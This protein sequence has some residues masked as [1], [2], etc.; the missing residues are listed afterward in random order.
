MNVES[1][2]EHYA[3]YYLD[4]VN[5][6]E[7]FLYEPP[8]KLMEQLGYGN[9]THPTQ[10]FLSQFSI[11]GEPYS[12]HNSVI[13]GLYQMD[14]HTV[15]IVFNMFKQGE[16]NDNDSSPALFHLV[17]PFNEEQIPMLDILS[18]NIAIID[19]C[20]D[21]E[22]TLG[23]LLFHENS[24]QILTLTFGQLQYQVYPIGRMI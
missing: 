13:Q 12:F 18:D 9:L 8:Y 22:N 10:H 2:L 23:I 16:E 11:N 1:Y 6:N 24:E 19:V 21:E 14:E 15:T 7:E 5:N 17:I 20:F 3:G 4:N